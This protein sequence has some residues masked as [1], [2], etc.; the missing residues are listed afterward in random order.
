MVP[1][2][3]CFLSSKHPQGSWKDAF[4]NSNLL[5]KLEMQYNTF[6]VKLK[7]ECSAPLREWINDN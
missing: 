7:A 1:V 6:N 2:E 3:E 4:P 5:S